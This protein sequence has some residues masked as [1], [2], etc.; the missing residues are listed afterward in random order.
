[1]NVPL[2]F[3]D[4]LGPQEMLIVGVIAILLFGE[5]LPEV[6][7]K[8]GASLMEFKK[9]VRGLQDEITSAT[10]SVTSSMTGQGSPSREESHEDRDEAT[11]P[12]FV[13][14]PR[15]PADHPPAA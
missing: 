12:K 10:N 2:A 6:G 13:P 1:M 14:P 7:R 3:F 9:S 15:P 11:A 8:F 4:S 5:K